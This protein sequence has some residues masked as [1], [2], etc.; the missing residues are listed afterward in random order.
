VVAEYIL[1]VRTPGAGGN[2]DTQ[3]RARPRLV[4][5]GIMRSRPCDAV[6]VT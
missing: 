3:G 5:V 1:R 6:I 4:H 2:M